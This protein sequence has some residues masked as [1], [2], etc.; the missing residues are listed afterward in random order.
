MPSPA[1]DRSELF[2][3]ALEGGADLPA[4]DDEL[5]RDLAVVDLLVR[6]GQQAGPDE[7]ERQRMRQRVLTGFDAAFADAKVEA[8]KE[9]S[10]GST[11]APVSLAER[12]EQRSAH[13]QASGT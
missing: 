11:T 5:R 13:R 7:A 1:D 6:A 2:A 9:A 3:R 10:A 8:D 4:P 12:R